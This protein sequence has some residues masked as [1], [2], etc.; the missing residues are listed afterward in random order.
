M[1]VKL[2]FTLNL[3]FSVTKMTEVKSNPSRVANSKNG[4]LFSCKSSYNFLVYFPQLL[5][6]SKNWLSPIDNLTYRI[7][8]VSPQSKI[9]F[10][11]AVEYLSCFKRGVPINLSLGI[12]RIKN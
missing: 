1:E 8:Y 2:I 10:S 6:L 4:L 7:D 5:L 3:R 12:N 9:N 11:Y